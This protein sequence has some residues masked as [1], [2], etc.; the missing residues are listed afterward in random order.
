MSPDNPLDDESVQP[1]DLADLAALLDDPVM[2]DQPDPGIEDLLLAA[3]ADEPG[4]GAT[5]SSTTVTDLGSWST[6]RESRIRSSR[7]VRSTV[8]F[9]AGIAAAL[10]AV[11][12][13]AGSDK[14]GDSGEVEGQHLALAGT[15]LAPDASAEA[16]VSEQALGV[17]IELD[18]SDLAP[19]PK[20]TYYQ[21]W[22][23]QDAAVGV[24]AGTFHMRG[25]NGVVFLWAGVTTKDYPLVTVTLQTEGEGPESSGKVVLKG[26]LE[27][28]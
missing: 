6:K 14:L 9:V 4:L 13:I 8:P 20:G 23:R 5:Q 24:S 25:G 27:D 12:F 26:L 3:I 28:S 17:V 7:L 15:A 11:F 21:A 19:A 2:W 18:V 22:V 16:I 10:L 1:D